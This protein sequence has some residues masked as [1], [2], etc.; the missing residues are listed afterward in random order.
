MQAIFATLLSLLRSF[1]G[2]PAFLSV[3]DN[4]VANAATPET[5]RASEH[6]L[7]PVI[8]LGFLDVSRFIVAPVKE[9]FVL[10]QQVVSLIRLELQRGYGNKRIKQV[11][12]MLTWPE[13]FTRELVNRLHGMSKVKSII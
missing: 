13:I 1:A 9:A 7:A 5:G 2:K 3:G 6:P 4:G 10:V 11:V 12:V 8:T